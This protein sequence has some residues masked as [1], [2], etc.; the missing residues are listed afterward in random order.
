MEIREKPD[1]RKHV[2]RRRTTRTGRRGYDPV[3]PPRRCPCCDGPYIESLDLT[4]GLET[5]G[6]RTCKHQFVVTVLMG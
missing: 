5:F 3:P 2:D 1:R 4:G 6:C